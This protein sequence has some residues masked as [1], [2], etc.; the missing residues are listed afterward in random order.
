MTRKLLTTT[1]IFTLALGLLAGSARGDDAEVQ[2]LRAENARLKAR[3]AQLEAEIAKLSQRTEKL[4]TEKEQLETRQATRQAK[5][6]SYFVTEAAAPNGG[7][8]LTTRTLPMHATH[9]T[10]DP[11]VLSFEASTGNKN[12]KLKVVTAGT[13]GIYRS[14]D[15]ITFDADGTSI[16]AKVTDYDSERRTIGSARTRRRAD[17]E[18][19]HATM[20]VEDAARLAAA[21][22]VKIQIRH[23]RFELTDE[24]QTALGVMTRKLK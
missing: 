5:S 3:V 17:N 11:H 24:Q 1:L 14:A 2:K 10:R 12:V 20:S 13:G 6:D 21:K 4:A 9:G 15:A 7:V 8:T 23:I 18:T 19:I 22:A 16:D